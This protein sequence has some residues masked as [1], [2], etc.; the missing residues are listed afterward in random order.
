M[1]G[2]RAVREASGLGG[3]WEPQWKTL[4]NLHFRGL[5]FQSLITSSSSL[6][7]HYLSLVRT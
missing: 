3:E 4:R 7:L 1:G 6:Q 5:V 2:S